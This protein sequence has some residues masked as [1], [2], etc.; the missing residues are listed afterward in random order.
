LK[1]AEAEKLIVAAAHWLELAERFAQKEFSDAMEWTN[2]KELEEGGVIPGAFISAVL[3][4]MVSLCRKHDY[5]F[6]D[7]LQEARE[8][9]AQAQRA[10]AVLTRPN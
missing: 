7:C 1:K 3:F 2:T 8:M 4:G 9:D 5:P 6:D 10:L